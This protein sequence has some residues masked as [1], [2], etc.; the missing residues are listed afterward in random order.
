MGTECP[1][2]YD[3]DDRGNVLW[4]VNE[5]GEVTEFREKIGVQ[6]SKVLREGVFKRGDLHSSVKAGR[7]SRIPGLKKGQ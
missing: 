5:P 1:A 7:K 4:K 3:S 6:E 2:D